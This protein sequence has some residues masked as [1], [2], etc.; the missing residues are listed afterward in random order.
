MALAKKSLA[1][2]HPE[3][4]KQ[5][6][7]WD[8]SQIQSNSGQVVSW[9]C[10]KE[11]TWETKVNY[12]V[13]RNSKCP[14]CLN[15]KVWVGFNDFATTHPEMLHELLDSA[16]T[17]FVA[18]STTRV[19]R[20]KC[21]LGHVYE[22]RPQNRTVRKQGCPFCAGRQVLEGFNDLLTTH[23]QIAS[24]RLP[25]RGIFNCKHYYKGLQARVK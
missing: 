11:H 24:E 3:L 25:T 17:D 7:G 9:K 12:R 8:P 19:C 6:V 4:A 15:Q 5:A 20:W 22:S 13:D 16:G 14:Y 1:E 21:N 2:T 18:G 23:P 10:K